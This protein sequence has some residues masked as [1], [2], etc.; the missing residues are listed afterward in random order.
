MKKG[1][2]LQAS[3]F[4]LGI[5]VLGFFAACGGKPELTAAP[6]PL[7]P[8]PESALE[9]REQ[10]KDCDPT[11]PASEMKPLPFEQ[12]VIPEAIRLADQGKVKMHTAESAEVDRM[13]REEQITE[14]VNDFLT[15]LA[16]DPYN[17]A[18]TYNLAAAYARI[19]RKQCSIN[20]LTRLLQMRGHAS[21]KP[22]VEANLDHLL[23]RNHQQ[24]D[25]DFSEMRR[26]DRFRELM[27]KM[28]EGS[29]DPNCVLGAH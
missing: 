16:A 27:R 24:L 5:L 18:A 12:R 7:R 6:P 3:G 22:E 8:E 13:T 17:V 25:G 4:R 21:K 11:D 15:A 28:C 19:G 9:P 14:A 2:R 20:L 1:F 10:Q 29:N 23:G 26:D